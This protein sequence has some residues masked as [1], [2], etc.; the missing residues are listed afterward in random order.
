MA[1]AIVIGPLLGACER[2]DNVTA[3]E[4]SEPKTR[5]PI[6]AYPETKA[7][8][9]ELAPEGRGLT[10]NQRAD[11]WRFVDSYR[12]ESTGPLHIAGP[13]S[14]GGYIAA[15]RSLREVQSIVAEVGVDPSDVVVAQ[16]G[17]GGRG[18]PEVRIAYEKP[19]AVPP[20]CRDWGSNLGENRERLPYNDFGCATQRNLALTVANARDLRQS[21]DETPRSSERR[22]KAW[23]EYTGSSNSSTSP[24]APASSGAMQPTPAVQ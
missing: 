24:A 18:A 10:P 9:V 4:L 22:S 11:V 23:G 1:I 5:H 12:K 6:G 17:G 2:L 15:S 21:Q 13:R 20:E 7:L 14:T 16:G 8:I 3:V 19:I